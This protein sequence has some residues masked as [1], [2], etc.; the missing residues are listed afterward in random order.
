MHG[1][2]SLLPQPY[3][4]QVITLWQEL[5]E[6]FHLKGIRVTPYPHFSWQ[7][8]QDY[9]FDHLEIILKEIAA[10]AR[11]FSVRTTGIGIFTGPKPVIYI[12]VVK[13]QQLTAF[14]EQVWEKTLPASQGVSRYYAPQS[15]VP[16]ISLAYDDVEKANA[17]SIIEYLAFSAYNWEIEVNHIGLIYE[18]SG[19]IGKLKYQFQFG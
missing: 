7:I 4:N 5:E 10:Q 19:E 12:P 3:Y 9:S 8:A 11:P 18:P 13:S 2:V 6:N 1:L 15:W 14:H 17:A 16:H